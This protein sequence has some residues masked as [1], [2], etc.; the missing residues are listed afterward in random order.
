MADMGL[1]EWAL[2][3]DKITPTEYILINAG[4]AV[5]VLIGAVIIHLINR[6]RY[7]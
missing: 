3:A 7:F 6:K 2:I 5:V 1:L 4:L